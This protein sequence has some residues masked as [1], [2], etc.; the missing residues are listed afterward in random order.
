[1]S[2]LRGRWVRGRRKVMKKPVRAIDMRRTA[3][4]LDLA[5]GTVSR[6]S[7]RTVVRSAYL[8]SPSCDL[9]WTM[10]LQDRDSGDDR[11]NARLRRCGGEF[12]FWDVGRHPPLHN[13]NGLLSLSIKSRV[14]CCHQCRISTKIGIMA[15]KQIIRLPAYVEDLSNQDR[16]HHET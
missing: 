16:G 5:C 14:R 12:P 10:R 4:V 9:E 1:L 3:T 2:I 6:V 13:N 15:T 7:H 8:S 11:F